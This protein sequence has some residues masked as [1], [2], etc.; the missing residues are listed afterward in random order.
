MSESS[1]P[2]VDLPADLESRVLEIL[3]MPDDESAAAMERL[4]QE[5]PE[6]AQRVRERLAEA[7]RL[8]AELDLML[9][10]ATAAGGRTTTFA[11][12]VPGPGDTFGDY[13]ILS[14]LGQGGM[15]TVYLAEQVSLRRRVALK[16]IRSDLLARPQSRERFRREVEAASQIEH[17]GICPLFEAGEIEGMPYIAMRYIQGE[18]LVKRVEQLRTSGSTTTTIWCG[19]S[20]GPPSQTHSTPSQ[21]PGSRVPVQEDWAVL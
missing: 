17:P 20:S 5:F 3:Q 19:S 9:Q 16:L 6:H 13:R 14:S 1:G 4:L 2:S 15:G 12:V 8:H 11:P 10:P 21:T 7:E 18:S